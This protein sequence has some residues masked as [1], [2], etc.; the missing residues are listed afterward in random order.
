ML[1]KR[2]AAEQ[3]EEQLGQG[4]GLPQHVRIPGHENERVNRSDLRVA[5]HFLMSNDL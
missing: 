3:V 5:T 2:G 1:I 4:C